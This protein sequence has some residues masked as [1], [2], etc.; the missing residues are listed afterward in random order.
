MIGLENCLRFIHFCGCIS[1]E[2]EQGYRVEKQCHEKHW[3]EH[4]CMDYP[5][6]EYLVVHQ[7]MD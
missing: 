6:L 7:E 2:S 5:D 4:L 1:E 3:L